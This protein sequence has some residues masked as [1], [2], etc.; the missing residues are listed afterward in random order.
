MFSFKVQ[1]QKAELN[2]WLLQ[3]PVH[4]WNMKVLPIFSSGFQQEGGKKQKSPNVNL[5]PAFL[6]NGKYTY[7]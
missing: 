2:V 1:F 7:H 6:M 5:F 4:H 3:T